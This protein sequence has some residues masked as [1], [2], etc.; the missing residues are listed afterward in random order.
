M[1]PAFIHLVGGDHKESDG[2][3]TSADDEIKPLIEEKNQK[4]LIILRL[5]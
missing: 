5:N 3:E 1:L 4:H 2:Y